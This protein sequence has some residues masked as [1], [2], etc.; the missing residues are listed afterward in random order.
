MPIHIG[1][2]DQYYLALVVVVGTVTAVIFLLWLTQ[3]SRFVK[4]IHSYRGIAPN[5]LSVM[6]MLFALNLAFL[7]ND[8]WSAH[9]RARHAVFQ[10]AGS[11]QTI[12]ALAD[13]LP[14][15]I[16]SKVKQAVRN[17]ARLTVTADWPMLAL[18]QSSPA[19]A[20]ELKTLLMLLSSEEMA[21]AVNNSV[22]SLMLQQ[23]VQVRSMRDLRIAL[24]HTHVNPLKWLGMAFLGF[25]TMISIAMVHVD[26]SRA[27]LLAI[28]LFAAAAVPTAAIIL[29]HGNPFQQPGAVTAAPIAAML[30]TLTAPG[31][32]QRPLP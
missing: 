10:E 6:G 11:L 23:F 4:Y 17:Y 27:E 32:D 30:D 29:V 5:F 9:D 22:Q 25:L 8:T 7:A 12:L 18:R 3:R 28:L 24:S 19:A 21:S 2:Y 20:N 13:Q 1:Q 14:D 16:Q 15:A 31:G 26:R